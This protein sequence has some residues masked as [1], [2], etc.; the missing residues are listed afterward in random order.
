MHA[1]GDG[2]YVYRIEGVDTASLVFHDQH[3]RQTADLRRERDGWMDRDGQWQDA[4]PRTAGTAAASGTAPA[5]AGAPAP[6]A[7]PSGVDFREE[8]IYFLITTR[9]YDGDPAN[10]FYC[11]DRIAFDPERPSDGPALAGRLQRA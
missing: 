10:N 1:H 11:R 7:P 5:A 4:D 9:F 8:T 2:W 3:G 6:Q